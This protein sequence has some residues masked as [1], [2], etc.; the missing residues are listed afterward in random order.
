MPYSPDF[1]PG[2]SCGKAKPNSD[3]H[4]TCL[5][6]LGESH[7]SDKCNICKGFKHLSEKDRAASLIHLLLESA[8]YPPSELSSGSERQIRVAGTKDEALELRLLTGIIERHKEV[9]FFFF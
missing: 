5:D 9:E 6:Y 3:P 2:C 1:K 4:P 7:V 8:L